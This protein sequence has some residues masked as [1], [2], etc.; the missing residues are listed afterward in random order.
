M[1]PTPSPKAEHYHHPQLLERILQALEAAGKTTSNLSRADIANIDEFHL[2]GAAVSRA[3]ADRLNVSQ[4][5]RVLDVG[6]GIGGPCRML[7][8]EFGCIVTGV[9]Y[10]GEYIRVA[11]ELSQLV[12]LADKTT[13]IEADARQLPFEDASF[14]IVWTQHVQMNIAE[15]EQFYGELYRVLKPEGKLLYYDVFKGPN[16]DITFPLP[17]A[18]TP[19][20]S[21]L[22][23]HHDINNYLNAAHWNPV[24]KEEH[25][26]YAVHA[27]LKALTI[28]AAS[29]TPP[30]GINLLMGAST[31]EKL[32]NLL[33]GL[34][35]KVFEVYAGIYQKLG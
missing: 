31:K 33:R 8:D 2:Q 16:P 1:P 34:Q 10:T 6:C 30:L 23:P 9:D 24:T 5:Q 29:T 19:A 15:K 3:L 11:Q 28:T 21:H 12:G 27:L 32:G 7:A 20:V 35:T 13:F 26:A 22:I 25:T 17:W 14:D 4:N 18:E